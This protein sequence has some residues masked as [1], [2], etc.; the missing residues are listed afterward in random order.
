MHVPYRGG[1]IWVAVWKEFPGHGR[2]VVIK[3]KACDDDP[4][5]REV[6]FIPFG[7]SFHL[8]ETETKPELTRESCLW[9]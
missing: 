6:G 7:D 5:K 9:Q 8:Y 1:W 2:T 3:G 4:G